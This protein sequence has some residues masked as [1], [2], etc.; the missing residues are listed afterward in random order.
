MQ[1]SPTGSVCPSFIETDLRIHFLDLD[2]L[3]DSQNFQ[4]VKLGVFVVMPVVLAGE[5]FHWLTLL[6]LLVSL[7]ISVRCLEPAD[8]PGA[9]PVS[10]LV[11]LVVP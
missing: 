9:I 6:S 8:F 10:F 3:N 1:H 11:S 7:V 2:L 5:P 4:P